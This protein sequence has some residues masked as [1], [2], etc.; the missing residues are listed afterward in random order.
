MWDR[1][2]VETFLAL[3]TVVGA[4]VGGAI[5]IAALVYLVYRL[6]QQ[7]AGPPPSHIAQAIGLVAISTHE[8]HGERDGVRVGVHWTTVQR[9]SG[10]S[11]RTVRVMRY[12]AT[13]EPSLRMG[14][15][16]GEQR[17]LDPLFLSL[18]FGGDITV[19]HRELDEAF[20]IK[21]HDALHAQRVLL[22]PP[23]A[24]ALLDAGRAGTLGVD[25]ARVTLGHDG[26][27][28]EPGPVAAK[29]GSVHRA[30][31]ALLDAR[32]R[33]RA[34][35]EAAVDASWGTM[36][37]LDGLTYD[38]TRTR[39]AGPTD[40]AWIQLDVISTEVGVGTSAWARFASPLGIGLH[41]Y[42]TG[43]ADKVGSLF[44]GQDVRC[45]HDAFDGAFTVKSTNDEAARVTLSDGAADAIVRLAHVS[46][47]VVV[48]DE[49]V[50]LTTPQL[51]CD[52]P[53]VALL[54]RAMRDAAA[55]FQGGGGPARG[56]YR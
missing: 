9:G 54:I 25:D 48:T 38:A 55:A 42:R 30:A 37:G 10:K 56:A 1:R 24:Q 4:F 50:R 31:L 22:E 16:I 39:L 19:H 29:I 7:N 44:G 43:L 49:G 45:G 13:L 18:G 6:A 20:L 34:A 8:A 21:A 33:H 2:A 27:L 46:H 15:G 36:A 11:R 51:V 12:W 14:F 26:W 32:R 5:G 35:W 17:A 3:L 23:V 47:D 52:G 41:I 40:D 28:R 53:T